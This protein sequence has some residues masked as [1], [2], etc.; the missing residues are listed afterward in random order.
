MNVNLTPQ[1]LAKHLSRGK[2]KAV[3]KTFPSA[4][5]IAADTFVV[6]EN[7]KI[8]KPHTKKRAVEMLSALSGKTH[9][10]ISGLTVIA[11]KQEFTEVVITKVTFRKLSKLDIDNYITRDKPLKASGSYKLQELGST[12]VERIEGDYLNVPGLPISKLI[13]ILK[14]LGIQIP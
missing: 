12:L 8:G 6:L 10:V 13:P 11:D 4:I 5:V 1:D 9:E 7:K 14:S 2:A 3:A